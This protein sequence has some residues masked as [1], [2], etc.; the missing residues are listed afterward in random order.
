MTKLEQSDSR[1]GIAI[2]IVL[3]MLSVLMVL[4][5]AFAI[6]MRTESA[7]AGY[8]SEISKSS[9]LIHTALARALADLDQNLSSSPRGA[10]Y[11]SHWPQQAMDTNMLNAVHLY[12]GEVTNLLPR[13]IYEVAAK[14]PSV[15]EREERVL[16]KELRRY[17]LD[18]TDIA[19]LTQ[20]IEE[21]EAMSE[22]VAGCRKHVP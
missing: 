13:G 6:S 12:I 1:S 8:Y 17:S 2:I 11:P 20:I 5:V 7:A 9:A 21:E 15:G 22:A 16:Q 4:A 10:S 14:L 18:D 3:G 19:A